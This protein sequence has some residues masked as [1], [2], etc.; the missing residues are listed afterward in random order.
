MILNMESSSERRKRDLDLM[1]QGLDEREVLRKQAIEKEEAT[2]LEK[3]RASEIRWEKMVKLKMARSASE[4]KPISE[5]RARKWVDRL[6]DDD[7]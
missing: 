1:F 7:D 2:E 4:G 3:M 6:L 5:E